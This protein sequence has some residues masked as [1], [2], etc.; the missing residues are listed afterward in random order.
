MVILMMVTVLAS[1]KPSNIAALLQSSSPQTNSAKSQ[2][3]TN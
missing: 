1:L 2:N 3:K